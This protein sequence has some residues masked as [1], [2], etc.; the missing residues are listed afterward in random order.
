M[1]MWILFLQGGMLPALCTKLGLEGWVGRGEQ[2]EEALD[3]VGGGGRR[4]GSLGHRP[5]SAALAFGSCKGTQHPQS[6]PGSQEP[7]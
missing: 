2:G 7:H 1:S 6:C 3:G 4:R 5:C